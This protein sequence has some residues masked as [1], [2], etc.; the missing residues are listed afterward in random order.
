MKESLQHFKYTEV[1]VY[2]Y[3]IVNVQCP[4]CKKINTHDISRGAG[5]RHCENYDCSGYTIVICRLC[6][7]S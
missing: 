4:F 1:Y 5:Y 7:L 6:V 2:G 3:D